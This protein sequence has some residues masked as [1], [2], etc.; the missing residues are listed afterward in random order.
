MTLSQAQ[1]REAIIAQL[2]RDGHVQ[3]NGLAEQLKVSVATIRR[4]LKALARDGL[5]E[6]TH[7][8]ATV[9]RDSDLSFMAKLTRNAEEKKTIG[10]LAAALV[11]DGDQV[12]LDSGTTCFHLAQ[13]LRSKRQL[14]VIVNSI[15]TAQELISPGVKVLLLG[16][17]FRPERMD[18]IGPM[19]SASLDQLRGYKAF[20]G[21][22]GL[23]MDFGPTATDIES[24]S[25]FGQAVRSARH[26]ILL[27]DH[28]KFD[29]PALYRIVEW[30][31]VA[32]IVTDRQPSDEWMQFFSSL[33][34]QVIYP[35]SG[36]ISGG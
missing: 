4:D 8:G 16:G 30:K 26:A 20:F 2:Y 3:I 15:R 5:L 9:R 35:G 14:C 36:S 29:A 23:G 10:R 12:F 11:Q 34:I 27:A 17:Q 19:A 22:D 21:T 13:Y 1:R 28:T 18:T 7:G 6:L 32:K 25:L 24:A 33:Q 31:S